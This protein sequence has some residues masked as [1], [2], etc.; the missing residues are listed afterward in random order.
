MKLTANQR[1]ALTELINIGFG[2]A[3]ATL[4]A[5]MSQRIILNVPE[6]DIASLDE[7]DELLLNYGGLEVTTIHQLFTGL[8]SGN[9]LL[10]LN[11]ESA[12]TLLDLLTDRSGANR[13]IT[14][15]DREALAEI[16]NIL[17]SAYVGSFG[18]ILNVNIRFAVPKIQTNN[19]RGM[20]ETMTINQVGIS[21]V[22]VVKT[23]FRLSEGSVT[24]HVLIVMGI[25]S[26][27]ALFKAI[28]D[29]GLLDG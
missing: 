22:L 2:R 15:S 11:D 4:S 19:V 24:G 10:I 14:S 6:I 1:D 7:L 17:L 28:D 16:G 13:R 9:A 29:T 12:T 26:L 27:D 20:L 21:Y 25:E 3:A 8:V 18:N 5:L 23:E